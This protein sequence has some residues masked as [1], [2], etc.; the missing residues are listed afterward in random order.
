MVI[1]KYYIGPIGP[2][3]TCLSTATAAG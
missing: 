1:C 2:S 3:A